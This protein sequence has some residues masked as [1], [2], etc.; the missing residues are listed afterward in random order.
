A[1][2]ELQPPDV[3]IRVEGNR[4][5]GGE[6][7]EVA[8]VVP[9]AP[10]R[11]LV[12][13]AGQGG[14]TRAEAGAGAAGPPAGGGAIHPPWLDEAGHL[15]GI[16]GGGKPALPIDVEVEAGGR[17]CL[18]RAAGAELGRLLIGEQLVVDPGERG[19]KRTPCTSLMRVQ[20]EAADLAVNAWPGGH[21][22]T[23]DLNGEVLCLQDEAVPAPAV[24]Q[25]ACAQPL[26]AVHPTRA[27]QGL[28]GGLL[29]LQV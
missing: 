3:A 23:S 18:E 8:L 20:R 17:Y 28:G 9:R 13:E 25:H 19:L 11:A 27:C 7:G 6:Q 10:L 21:V 14:G 24:G 22:L 26:G 12:V 29:L 2:L 5:A 1:Q 15:A 16:E 4:V